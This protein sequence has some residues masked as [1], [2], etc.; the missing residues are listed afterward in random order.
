MT[1]FFKVPLRREYENSHFLAIEASQ[2]Q[3]QSYFRVHKN[4][5]VLGNFKIMLF[6]ENGQHIQFP[7][8]TIV[9]IALTFRP[10]SLSYN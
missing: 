1:T 10:C 7:R 9:N 5:T 2:L 8:D 3:S 6:D 4:Q